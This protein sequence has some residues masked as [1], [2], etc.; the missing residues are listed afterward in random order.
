M[1]RCP[2]CQR[3]YADDTLRF[4]L[5]DG[6]ALLTEGPATG[7]QTLLLDSSQGMNEPPPTEILDYAVPPTVLAEDKDATLR[8]RKPGPTVRQQGR[9]TIR[10][11]ADAPA[12]VPAVRGRSTT[13]VVAVTV[14][15]TLLLLGVGGLGAWLVLKDKNS[16]AG[17]SESPRAANNSTNTSPNGANASKSNGNT[18]T[19]AAA[20]PMQTP[21]LT[22]TPSATPSPTPPVADTAA[23]RKEVM[24]A[25]NGW[26]QT[27]GDLDAHMAYYA[28]TLHTYYLQSNVSAGR[29]RAYIAPAF[30][31]YD[32]FDVNLSNVQIEVDPSGTRAV[33]TF[34]KTFTFSGD[35]TY[36]GSGLN[37]FWLEKI[38]G[39]WLITGEKDLKTYYVNK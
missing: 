5:E 34:D 39:R 10:E 19:V 28:E 30:S 24:Q 21:A 31:K 4:C 20:T 16:S 26:R 32:T 6:S 13:S 38:N 11:F 37:R 35:S 17:A 18:T 9:Q 1:K 8:R 22:P 7:D 36:S 27:M 29:V 23:A 3:T 12:P 25:L 2:T 14:V 15:A 33:A